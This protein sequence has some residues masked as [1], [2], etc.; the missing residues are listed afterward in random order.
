M[1]N[2]F[3]GFQGGAD[4]F[5]RSTESAEALTAYRKFLQGDRLVEDATR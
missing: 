2:L 1:V 5:G 3:G 4:E